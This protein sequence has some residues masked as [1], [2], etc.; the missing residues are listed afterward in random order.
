MQGESVVNHMEKTASNPSDEQLVASFREGSA[1]AMEIIVERYG[2]RILRFG[3]KMCGHLQD[4]EDISQETFLSAFRYL[5]SFRGE[6]RLI[7]WLF[8][9]ASRACM[10]KR[11]KKKDE[12]D[13]EISLDA[14]L[15][16][17]PGDEGRSYQI[18][19]PDAGPDA[20]LDRKE[21]KKV[22]GEAMR[23]LPPHYRIVLNLRD[24]EGFSTRET[25]DILEISEQAI[26]TRL[27][28][29]RLFMREK[30]SEYF[31]EEAYG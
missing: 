6:T 15:P 22:I 13:R 26:K 11:R 5:D 4:A 23:Q 3:L 14:W 12:P 10:R 18:P 31:E 21:M 25:A 19:D 27:H 17:R 16:E 30:I 2:N 20:H 29:A 8:K 7:N 1:E 24:V 9:I 28:R